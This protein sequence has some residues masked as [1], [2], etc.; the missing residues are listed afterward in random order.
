M[1]M[2]AGFSASA[3]LAVLL[4]APFT[5]QAAPPKACDLLTAQGAASLVGGPTT[6]AMDS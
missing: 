4:I 6:P 5:A 2:H 3:V 1:R